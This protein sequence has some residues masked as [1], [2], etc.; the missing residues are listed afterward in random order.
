[1]KIFFEYEE[2]EELV[3]TNPI[4]LKHKINTIIFSTCGRMGAGRK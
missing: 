1:M 4:H 3:T 2:T